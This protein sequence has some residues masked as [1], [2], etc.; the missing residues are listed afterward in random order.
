MMSE[1]INTSPVDIPKVQEGRRGFS[2]LALLKS[3]WWLP[4]SYCI[5]YLLG[6]YVFTADKMEDTLI[7]CSKASMIGLVC[8]L[9]IYGIWQ[10]DCRFG[11]KQ[12]L[13]NSSDPQGK[14]LVYIFGIVLWLSWVSAGI[15]MSMTNDQVFELTPQLPGLSNPL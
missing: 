1:T 3:F 2:S 4:A 8:A 15:I 6:R 11:A 14:A 9:L 12:W 10:L 7:R 13:K 5:P